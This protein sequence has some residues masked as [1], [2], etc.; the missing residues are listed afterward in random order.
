MM[1]C[2]SPGGR[3]HDYPGKVFAGSFWYSSV[4][5]LHALT[6]SLFLIY[7]KHLAK[8]SLLSQNDAGAWSEHLVVI[9]QW[10]GVAIWENK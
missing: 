9:V 4:G 6:S 8:V 7:C 5:V 3:S 10:D 1:P 2:H